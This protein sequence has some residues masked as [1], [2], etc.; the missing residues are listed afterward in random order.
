MVTTKDCGLELPK[1]N[2]KCWN[3]K[4]KKLRLYPIKVPIKGTNQIVVLK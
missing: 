1:A 2:T 4:Y 3:G